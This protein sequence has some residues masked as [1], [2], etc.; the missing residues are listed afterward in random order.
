MRNLDDTLSGDINDSI[1]STTTGNIAILLPTSSVNENETQYSLMPVIINQPPIITTNIADASSPKIIPSN[2]ANATGNNLHIFPDGTIKVMQGS[3]FELKIEAKQPNTLNVENGIPTIKQ[4]NQDLNY[5]WKVNDGIIRTHEKQSLQSKTIVIGN[6][7]GFER[8]QPE[9]AGTYICEISNDIG[10]VI[11]SPITIE[12]LNP[13]LDAYFYKNLIINGSAT[14]GTTGWEGDTDTLIAR[15]LSKRDTTELKQPNRVDIFG[16]NADTMHPRP[17]QLEVG[18]VKGIDYATDFSKKG[19]GGYFSRDVYKFEKA[20]GSFFVKAYQDIDVS[21]IQNQIKGSVYGIAGVR[22]IF[23]CY[24]GN[25]ISQY[26]PTLST[27]FPDQRIDA[28]NYFMGAPRVSLEN[29]LMAG[30]G[31]VVDRCYVTIEEFDSET[32]LISKILQPNGSTTSNPNTVT[33]T[34]PWSKRISN[35]IGKR[36]YTEDIYKLGVTSLGNENDATLFTADE[37]YPNPNDRPT[38]GQ[39]LEFNRLVIERLNPSTTKIRVSLNYITNDWRIFN[40]FDAK[41]NGSDLIFE[42]IGWE[43]NYKKATFQQKGEGGEVDFIQTILSK[44]SRYKDKPKTEQIPLAPPPR[45]AI[46]GLSLALIPIEK[47]KTAATNHYTSATFNTNSRPRVAVPSALDSTAVFDPLDVLQRDMYVYFKHTS[48]STIIYN[49]GDDFSQ[50]NTTRMVLKTISPNKETSQTPFRVIPRSVFPFV[51]GQSIKPHTLSRLDFEAS[52]SALDYSMG[53]YRNLVR[54]YAKLPNNIDTK[55]S[56]TKV[57]ETRIAVQAIVGQIATLNSEFN[58]E[59]KT[60]PTALWK[61][62]FRYVLHYMTRKINQGTGEYDASVG[63]TNTYFLLVDL[64]SKTPIKI[65]KDGSLPGGV[66]VAPSLDSDIQKD[67][68][69]FDV[70]EYQINANGELEFTLPM[71]MLTADLVRGGLGIPLVSQLDVKLDGVQALE[72]IKTTITQAEDVANNVTRLYNSYKVLEQEINKQLDIT[73]PLNNIP[74][75]FVEE[76]LFTRDIN[77]HLYGSGKTLAQLNQDYLINQLTVGIVIIKSAPDPQYTTTLYA[78]SMAPQIGP[79][80]NGSPVLGRGADGVVYTIK[81]PRVLDSQT[82]L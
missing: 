20:G 37:L 32:R 28:K 43:K 69:Q 27:L 26:I 21:E 25:A 61:D 72:Y 76:V 1:S 2:I 9:S 7:I 8:I 81:Y 10:L 13:D 35:H 12:V 77:A 41:N 33:L 64:D 71:E 19:K 34:D 40:H 75:R 63:K 62:K 52:I 68:V 70:L 55:L 11:S 54:K 79:N 31:K 6:V 60:N 47:H 57:E 49:G 14:D 45:L 30:P 65:Y 78:V 50:K 15:E 29:F 4:A 23:G 18:V 39:Y 24:I 46:T 44:D 53:D 82:N 48:D 22:A 59:G 67:Y 51:S 80:L 56:E 66:V 5:T 42:T 38:H 58:P 74:R 16:Y 3:T 17:Y 73:D 36:Y